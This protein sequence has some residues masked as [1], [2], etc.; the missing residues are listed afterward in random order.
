V[1][2]SDEINLTPSFVKAK[3]S[4]L[5]SSWY[6]VVQESLHL[7]F[8]DV[9]G[10]PISSKSIA[11]DLWLCRVS[12][13]SVHEDIFQHTCVLPATVGYNADSTG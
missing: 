2:K 5:F 7:H 10:G 6:G 8:M 1:I 3:F 13:G 12:I 11:H 9:G 4:V